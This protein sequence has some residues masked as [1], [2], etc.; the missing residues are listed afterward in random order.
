ME[1]VP[2]RCAQQPCKEVILVAMTERIQQSAC[3][4]FCLR[5]QDD[6]SFAPV[7][8]IVCTQTLKSAGKPVADL[9]AKVP[10]KAPAPQTPHLRDQAT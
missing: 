8:C 4:A 6:Q 5:M 3:G 9:P 1:L 2:F 7:R 10:I